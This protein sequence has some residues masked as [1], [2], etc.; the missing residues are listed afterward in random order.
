MFAEDGLNP[1]DHGPEGIVD[2]RDP[3]GAF[4]AARFGMRFVAL[5]IVVAIIYILVSKHASTSSSPELKE[6]ISAVDSNLPPQAA[7]Q[8]GAPAAPARTDY[9]RAIDRANAVVNE[10]HRQ[11]KEQ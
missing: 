4:F 2:Q 3:H 7:Q 5:L 10:V 9:K 11:Q 6:A 1:A 8:G